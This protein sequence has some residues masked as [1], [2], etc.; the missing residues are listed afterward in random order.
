LAA[1][2]VVVAALAAG[3]A[4]AT[5]GTS[6]VLNLCIEGNV[7]R[8]IETG[9]ACKAKE[10]N[11]ELYTKSG[12]DAAIAAANG[13]AHNHDDR[14]YTKPEA[15]AAFLGVGATAADSD[16]LDGLD[17]TA[18]LGVGATAAD[19]DKLD[20]LDST[21]FLGVGATAADSDKLDGLDAAAFAQKGFLST[22]LTATIPSVDCM[23]VTVDPGFSVAAG[24]YLAS[25]Y[26]PNLPAGVFIRGVRVFLDDEITFDVCN[27]SATEVNINA[28]SVDFITLR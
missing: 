14:Y 27:L 18:F 25:A 28:V 2:P 15:D 10:Q 9:S 13:T 23:I 6:G 7:V 17:S 20:G 3:I 5:P 4:Q 19:S 26:A 22:S 11:T 16:K 21:A 8:A 24:T 12:T 1:V